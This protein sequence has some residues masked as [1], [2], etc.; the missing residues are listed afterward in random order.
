MKH[1]LTIIESIIVCILIGCSSISPN[2]SY[3]LQT[4]IQ[5][6][7]TE[8]KI[9]TKVESGDYIPPN[10][11]KF[12]LSQYTLNTAPFEK[13]RTLTINEVEDD[14]EVLFQALA[15]YYAP[16]NYFGG[17]QR[18]NQAKASILEECHQNNF[19]DGNIFEN[20]LL[21]NFSFIQDGHFCI[22]MKSPIKSYIPFFY[23]EI[24]FQRTDTGY[25]T[26]DGK[27]V[28]SV[29]GYPNLDEL[30]K[31]SISNGEIIYYPITFETITLNNS[32]QQSQISPENLIIHYTDGSSQ[33]L[34]ADKYLSISNTENTTIKFYKNDEIPILRINHFDWNDGGKELL[35]YIK[36]LKDSPVLILDLRYNNGGNGDVILKCL[37]AYTEKSVT[38]NSLV[39][40]GGT[41]QISKTEPDEFV[42]NSKFLILLTSKNTASSAE[43]AI[44][45]AYNI[46]NTIIIGENTAGHY[47]SNAGIHMKLPNSK[48]YVKFGTS[49]TIFPD[50]KNFFSET[51]GFNPDIWCNATNAEEEAILLAKKLMKY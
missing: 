32:I 50:N 15:G 33:T 11:T 22:N 34:T 6:I 42:E 44:D 28:K 26:L 46:Q 14:I 35:N 1:F 40:S 39:F 8:H 3:S 24:D 47:L 30:F 45:I 27:K 41:F 18:F 43:L 13:S 29:V 4:L 23:R 31:R 10:G 48:I 19:I 49:F 12:N 36:D 21:K 16:Y 51:Y 25:Q 20:I 7:N 9:I 2:S 17:T 38:A 37:R 5:N